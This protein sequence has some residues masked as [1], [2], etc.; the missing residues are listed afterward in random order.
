VPAAN[1]ELARETAR[2]IQALDFIPWVATPDLGSLGVGAVEV[3][4]RRIL[5]VHSPLQDEYELSVIDSARLL[6]TPINYLGYVPEY[7]DAY[8]LPEVALTGRYAGVVVWLTKSTV[9]SEQQKL[10]SWLA[11]QVEAKVPVALVTP[12][13]S[14]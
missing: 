10:A 1:R 4:P 2:R 8:H 5:V 7:V 3:L 11:R 13:T 9:A 6:S 12:S 14:L